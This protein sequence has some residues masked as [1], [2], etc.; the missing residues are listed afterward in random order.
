MRKICGSD[1]EVESAGLEPAELNPLVI[2]VLAEEGIDIRGKQTR[3]VFEVYR[4]GRLYSHVITVCDEA[5]A[6]RCPIFPGVVN[7]LHWSFADPSKFEGSL[8]ER[9]EQVRNVREQIRQ[10]IYQF[11][12]EN[13]AVPA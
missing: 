5:S 12:D 2:D 8:E 10:Q 6:E 7:R 1:V 3:D 13:C 9:L 11:C 4:T